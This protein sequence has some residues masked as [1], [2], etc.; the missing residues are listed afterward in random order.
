MSE[1]GMNGDVRRKAND[2][3]KKLNGIK[4]PFPVVSRNG[5]RRVPSIH[6]SKSY[7][8]E[9]SGDP[10]SS[11]LEPPPPP[12]PTSSQR[13]L[14]SSPEPLASSPEPLASS[15]EPSSSS[16]EQTQTPEPLA[17]APVQTRRLSL[18][19]ES[20]DSSPEISPYS[21]DSESYKSQDEEDSR[22]SSENSRALPQ[23]RTAS[24]QPSAPASPQASPQASASSKTPAA[25]K[26]PETPSLWSITW[27]L[28]FFSHDLSYSKST[29]LFGIGVI[30]SILMTI[31]LTTKDVTDKK[32]PLKT[33][34][35]KEKKEARR[36]SFSTAVIGIWLLLLCIFAVI[37]LI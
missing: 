36:N 15:P 31:G 17:S 22:S 19:D 6:E 23:T 27:L 21:S 35:P 28:P 12:P 10:L 29:I 37:T 20:D 8:L 2:I 11:V 25:P 5:R 18:R 1:F 9:Q 4:Q 14:A 34:D 33:S 24:S 7:T 30:G 26:P 13:P 32:G 16:S 3:E